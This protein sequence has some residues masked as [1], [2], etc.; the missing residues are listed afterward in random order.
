M[1]P[2]HEPS[3]GFQRP[4]CEGLTQPSKIEIIILIWV[5]W[6]SMHSKRS[7][8]SGRSP[9]GEAFA[10]HYKIYPPGDSLP[11]PSWEKGKFPIQ[12]CLAWDGG[13]FAIRSPRGIFAR[14][15]WTTLTSQGGGWTNKVTTQPKNHLELQVA[16]RF[17]EMDGCLVYISNHFPCIKMWFILQFQ[18]L[19]FIVIDSLQVPRFQLMK[20]G[21]ELNNGNP[22]R[23]QRHV[24]GQ[25]DLGLLLI[26][27]NLLRN[28]F[29][30]ILKSH[31]VVLW[32]TFCSPPEERIVHNEH[33][34]PKKVELFIWSYSIS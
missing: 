6:R 8:A 19:K 11:H 5:P 13:I 14:V 22:N 34:F 16:H 26:R 23:Q 21:H 9:G 30:Q 33:H 2:F 18:P 1:E 17:N 15:Y 25:P 10:S 28:H 32:P 31:R 24:S 7:A 12:K 4:C 27:M 29:N 20:T 3:F